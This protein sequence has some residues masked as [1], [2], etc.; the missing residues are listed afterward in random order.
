[1]DADTRSTTDAQAAIDAFKLLPF[2]GSKDGAGHKGYGLM[3]W[4]DIFCGALSGSGFTAAEGEA[5]FSNH[6]FGA[7]RIDAFAPVVEYRRQMDERMRNLRSSRP[8]PGFERVLVAG[9]PEWEN[10][11]DRMVNGVPLH[12]SVV[13]NLRSLAR[14]YHLDFDLAD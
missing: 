4:V 14:K 8:A 7:W 2:G 1:L 10:Q 3:V 11:Q 6:F 13:E 9:V 12:R 5:P